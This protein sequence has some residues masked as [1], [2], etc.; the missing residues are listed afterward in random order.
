MSENRGS[1]VI[2]KL[3]VVKCLV[4]LLLKLHEFNT[5]SKKSWGMSGRIPN[6]FGSLLI[7]HAG[8]TVLLPVPDTRTHQALTDLGQM[9]PQSY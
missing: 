1:K 7:P 8:H 5:M 2:L 3:D 6:Y 4:I 9:F